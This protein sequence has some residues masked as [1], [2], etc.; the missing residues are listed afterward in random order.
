MNGNDASLVGV[1]YCKV[2]VRSKIYATGKLTAVVSSK[3]SYGK[4]LNIFHACSHLNGSLRHFGLHVMVNMLQ[5]LHCKYC[6][7]KETG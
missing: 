3:I 1:S 7:L 4:F 6:K 5:R 2:P